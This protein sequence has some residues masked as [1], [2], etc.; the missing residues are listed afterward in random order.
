MSERPLVVLNESDS[1]SYGFLHDLS[2]RLAHEAFQRPGEVR[3][4]RVAGPQDDVE[5]RRALVQKFCC[6]LCPFDLPDR[7]KRETSRTPD[8]AFDGSL[9]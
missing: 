4:V 2:R 6:F 3:L 1:R 8:P 5:D 9:T 7:S